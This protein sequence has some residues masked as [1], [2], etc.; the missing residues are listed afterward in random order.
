ME[1]FPDTVLFVT[2]EGDSLSAE[3]TAMAEKLKEGGRRKIIHVEMKGVGHSFDKYY[4]PMED[5]RR[6]ESYKLAAEVLEEVFGEK[7]DKRR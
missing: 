1:P 7:E 4:G 5:L 6:E 3:G 2:S